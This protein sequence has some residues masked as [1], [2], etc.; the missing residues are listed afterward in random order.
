MLCAPLRV[1]DN[2]GLLGLRRKLI[3][4]DRFKDKRTLITLDILR[5]HTY[6]ADEFGSRVWDDEIKLMCSEPFIYYINTF[7]YIKE[8]K[9]KR[10]ECEAFYA[11]DWRSFDKYDWRL[12]WV[13]YETD[14]EA[15]GMWIVDYLGLDFSLEQADDSPD[16]IGWEWGVLENWANAWKEMKAKKENRAEVMK[17]HFEAPSSPQDPS[18]PQEV[19]DHY[20]YLAD[21]RRGK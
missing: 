17:D 4:M 9:W 10:G 12:L 21:I 7:R 13:D 20:Q 16:V 8:E 3:A 6:C 14:A 18:M 15:L 1:L 5:K 19:E 11:S 2:A